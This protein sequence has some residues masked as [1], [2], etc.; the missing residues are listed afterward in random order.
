MEKEITSGLGF[1]IIGIL[2]YFLKGKLTEFQ[3]RFDDQTPK[4]IREKKLEVVSLASMGMGL[5]LIAI[6]YFSK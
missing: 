2:G 1:L 5:V 6:Y 4:N 3:S